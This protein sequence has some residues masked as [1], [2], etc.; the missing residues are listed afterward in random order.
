MDCQIWQSF[1]LWIELFWLIPVPVGS[2]RGLPL[3]LI[4]LRLAETSIFHSFIGTQRTCS[5]S[6]VPISPFLNARLRFLDPAAVARSSSRFTFQPEHKQRVRF[7]RLQR[8]SDLNGHFRFC[9]LAAVARPLVTSATN[10]NTKNVFNLVAS[11]AC[12]V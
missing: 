9:D 8:I 4:Q 1:F 5:H 10:S 3:F 11:S 7:E 2:K 12:R 6:R